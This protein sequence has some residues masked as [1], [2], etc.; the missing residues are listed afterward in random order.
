[1]D[2]V[3]LEKVVLIAA[4]VWLRLKEARATIVTY[5][6]LLLFVLSIIFGIKIGF[7]ENN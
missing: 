4:L 3:E 2:C 5:A 7:S 6:V 1:M